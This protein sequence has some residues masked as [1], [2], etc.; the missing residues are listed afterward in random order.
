MIEGK[1]TPWW[2]RRT[3]FFA[4]VFLSVV[5]LLRPDVA[6]L[7]DLPAHMG[8][9][10]VELEIG[11]DAILRQF[12]S[13]QWQLIGNLGIDLL[14]IPFS[15]LFGL[16]SAIKIIVCA[17][18]LLTALGFLLVAKEVHGRLP[19][20]AA[21]ALPL[22]YGFPLQFGFVNFALSMAFG[23]LGFWLWLKLAHKRLFRL[24]AII[25]VPLSALI[26]ITHT[27]GWGALC[28]VAFASELIRHHDRGGSWLRSVSGAL[29]GCLPLAPPAL[30]MLGWRTG[31]VGGQTADMFNWA[32]KYQYFLMTLRDRWALF[33][34]G[35]L[36]L[37]VA[38]IVWALRRPKAS[39]SRMLG[40][41]ALFLFV[42]FLLLPRIVFGSA[43][44]DMRLAPFML[45]VGLIALRPPANLDR[46]SV[47][48]IA[49]ASLAFFLVRTAGTT[50]S[51]WLYDQDYDRQAAAIEHI[52]QHAR[53]VSFVEQKACTQPWAQSRLEHFPSL[54][55]V[56]K[57]AFANDQWQMPGAQLLRVR[58]A[59]GAPLNADPM[60]VVTPNQCRGE[61]WLRLDQAL[62]KLPRAA[63]DYVWIINASDYDRSLMKGYKPI[64]R[65]GASI[66]YRKSAVARAGA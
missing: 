57:R 9:Y 4:L 36:F 5:P 60:Q 48:L 2:E 29:L 31:H 24:R 37:L 11:T 21:L 56:R 46:R 25:F 18:P 15:K 30:L 23:F 64:W 40:I 13:F 66:L 63:Y 49:A 1:G 16:E 50:A 17:I 35:S 8:H 33:D 27:Y 62:S 12:Y 38:V 6:P 61:Y 55:L 52:P 43:Y 19:P 28:V 44:A 53:L 14:V 65:D 26:W 3:Y 41:S 42:T 47:R 32:I 10:R 20:T 45:A 58:Y 22:A 59:A 54:A 7:T 34:I 39:F 51:F